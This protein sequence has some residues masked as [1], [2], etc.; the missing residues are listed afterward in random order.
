M[1]WTR[2]EHNETNFSFRCLDIL[3][4]NGTNLPLQCFKMDGMN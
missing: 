4:W 3:R 2:M 1:E